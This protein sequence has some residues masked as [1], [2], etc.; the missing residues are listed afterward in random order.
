[1]TNN[2]PAFLLAAGILSALA[3]TAAAAQT[4]S[5]AGSYNGA[6]TS[7]GNWNNGTANWSKDANLQWL[8][9]FTTR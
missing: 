9:N 2:R 7:G 5:F 1:M 4:A 8:T 3:A 6:S